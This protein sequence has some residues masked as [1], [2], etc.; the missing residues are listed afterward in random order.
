MHDCPRDHESLNL[1]TRKRITTLADY[2]LHLHG[3]TFK[4]SIPSVKHIAGLIYELAPSG[5]NFKVNEKVAI[6]LPGCSLA[7][8]IVP[9]NQ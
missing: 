2:S 9:R 8:I 5:E 4:T 1:T 6:L 3:Q 7:F